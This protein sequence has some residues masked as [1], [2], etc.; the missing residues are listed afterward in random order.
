[1]DG[2][3]QARG[4]PARP[5]PAYKGDQPYVFV[6]YAH[7]D[8]DL[9]YPELSWLVDRGCNIWY[10]EG[11]APGE[12]WTEEL[13]RA[14][15]G[16]SHFLYFVTPDSIQSRNCRDE[17]NFALENDQHLVAVH[18][19][20]TQL[21]GGLRLSIGLTQ[22]IL[23]HELEE[24]SYR[25]KL[26]SAL[27]LDAEDATFG[28]NLPA[29]QGVGGLPN[30]QTL[31]PPR[32]KKTARIGLGLIAVLI[33]A[34]GSL[35]YGLY[36][37]LTTSYSITV[38]P[39]TNMSTDEETGYFAEG[40]SESIVDTL[41][42]R[43]FD[44]PPFGKLK[45]VSFPS[46]D[47]GDGPAT[48]ADTLDVAYV[49]EGSVQRLADRLHITTQLIRAEDNAHVWSESY[50]RTLTDG[51]DM[52]VGVAQNVVQVVEN[53]LRFDI[54]KRYAFWGALAF[55]TNAE[56]YRHFLNAATIADPALREQ[57]LRKAVEAD[58]EFAYAYVQLAQIY[59]GR[60]GGSMSLEQ[61]SLA[62]HAAIDQ[63]IALN[64]NETELTQSLGNIY[65]GLDLDYAN[66]AAIFTQTGRS[67]D[68]GAKWN[69]VNLATIAL[70][71]GRTQDALTHMATAS[72]LDT[73]RQQAPFL[74][75]Y[76]W[77]LFVAGD[78]QQ[79]LETYVQAL[80]F[81]PVGRARAPNL[82][83]Q[84]YALIHLG[85]FEQARSVLA[86]AWELDGTV[87]PE[88]YI[89]ALVRVGERERAMRILVEAQ[90]TDRSISAESYL[91]VQDLDNTFRLIEAAIEDQD[92]RML[93]TLRGAKWWDPI[94]ED[95]RFSEMLELLDSKESHT[96]Q[97]VK[98]QN[99]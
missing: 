44:E 89:S 42:E 9:V 63:A 99:L 40:L 81:L 60:I 93:D 34:V 66:A 61:A 54:I 11:I 43:Q 26:L 12:E 4:N 83:M 59:T 91:A 13:A 10:D 32:W 28:A 25:E 36:N 90:N 88:A 3:D 73:G 31:R 38:L 8:S 80:N 96:E 62:A 56:A 74:N 19:K 72:V 27:K 6:C 70:R 50:E 39:F 18:L 47:T 1:M 7:A 87:N 23:K 58:P 94:R 85:K 41:V 24:G 79:T 75:R 84:M 92:G 37:D 71:E 16:A 2:P 14:I 67:D 68:P 5:L 29:E 69:H 45:V 17:V 64:P 65:L 35:L 30:P 22:A 98:A 53:R 95:P 33:V 57:D 48:I 21:T 76:A 20:E 86:E 97:Y 51:F 78:Y 46:A 52:Q 82:R 77:V 49:L 15:E 55:N